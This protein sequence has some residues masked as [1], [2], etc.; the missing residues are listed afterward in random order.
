MWA[1][2]WRTT[3]KSA[4]GGSIFYGYYL[5]LYVKKK[6]GYLNIDKKKLIQYISECAK[7]YKDNLQNKNIM[8]VYYTGKKIDY[9]ETKFTASN[10]LHLTGLK[11]LNKKITAGNFIN[12]ILAHRIS[13]K[14]I[15]EKEDGTTKL[16]LQVLHRLMNIHK[17]AKLIGDYNNNR[18]YLF[19]QKIIGD[20]YSCMGIIQKNNY[21]ICN[22]VL[23]EDIRKLIVNQKKIICILTK[24]IPDL[25][26]KK[27]TY[28]NEKYKDKIFEHEEIKQKINSDLLE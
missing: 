16:K 15:T 8:F 4:K 1:Y 9:I 22:T 10:F 28:I 19:S 6:E 2:S 18:I 14:D 11:L 20:T 24:N 27:I 26:Y 12:Q 17:N 5:L 23:K 3:V 7:L 21:F 25:K 13:K